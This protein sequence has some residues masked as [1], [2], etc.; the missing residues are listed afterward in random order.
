M[1][2]VN[3]FSKKIGW[4]EFITG[5]MFAGKTAELIRRLHRL[6]YADVKYLVF[7]PKIDTR[8]I[9]NIQSR[10]GTSLPSVEVESAPEILNYIMSNSFNDETKVIGIDEVQFFDDRICE[11]ANILAENGF[12][13]IISGLDKNFKGEPFGPIAKLFT[14]ADKIT[15]LTAICNECGAEAT[16]SLRKIDGKHAD[17]NDDIVKIG[18]QEFYSA[19]CRHHHKVPNRPYLNSNSEEFIK[20]FKN[21]KRN[22]NI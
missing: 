11:V 19:V 6:E 8:S 1:A 3:A 7:K 5:P 17:Y 9:R 18:C 4:I 21:K 16:H 15:K 20:F 10:T 12:V 14:Y 22:K 2:K 13:V